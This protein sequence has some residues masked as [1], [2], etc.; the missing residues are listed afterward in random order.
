MLKSETISLTTEFDEWIVSV[1][2]QQAC[3]EGIR[4]VVSAVQESVA[5]ASAGDN[6]ILENELRTLE[7]L[8]VSPLLMNLVD[9]PRQPAEEIGTIRNG[10]SL[11]RER[12]ALLAQEQ[13]C[14]G[15]SSRKSQLT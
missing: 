3:Q 11:I 9:S 15:A 6:R 1:L 2:D 13:V 8:Y 12:I 5:I 14:E 7:Q 4:S 10:F